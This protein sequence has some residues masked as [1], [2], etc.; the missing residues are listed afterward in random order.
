MRNENNCEANVQRN[1]KRCFF[2]SLHCNFCNLH[3]HTTYNWWS[4]WWCAVII[5]A[6]DLIDGVFFYGTCSFCTSFFPCIFDLYIY[7]SALCRVQS[8]FFCFRFA[9]GM[10]TVNGC[11]LIKLLCANCFFVIFFAFISFFWFY[12]VS[13]CVFRVHLTFLPGISDCF[14]YSLLQKQLVS[15]KYYF[16][17]DNLLIC[18]IDS[19]YRVYLPFLYTFYYC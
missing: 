12:G 4:R 9:C 1:K 11:Y 6:F 14:R 17:W 15:C 10:F 2:L 13:L 7:I 3:T 16:K 5:V 8:V 18:L 19:F